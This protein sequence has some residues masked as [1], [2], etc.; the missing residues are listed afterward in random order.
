M[1]RK[2]SKEGGGSYMISRLIKALPVLI[3][4]VAL[5][6]PN[7]W[8]G[9]KKMMAIMAAKNDAMRGLTE[10]V[11]G[12]KVRSS[13]EVKNMTADSYVGKT[14][15]KTSATLS[16]IKITDVVYDSQ[17]DIA[18]ATA[19]MT[20]SEIVNIE[21]AN[22]AL[23][24]KVFKHVGFGTSSPSSAGPLKALRAAQI[25]AY[26]QLA[27]QIAGFTLESQTSVENYMLKSDLIQTKV[28][29]SL[30]LSEIVDFGWDNSGDAYV[31]MVLRVDE[32]AAM[33]GEAVVG[34]GEVIEVEGQGAI[35][36]DFKKAKAAT[37][38]P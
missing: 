33:L 19:T 37:K 29:A 13:E 9:N 15:S 20:A 6:V 27:Q 26:K 4:C 2:Y 1:A 34:A 22:V 18:K 10:Q 12:L 36:D 14:D 11:Y 30:A 16:G 17:K 38:K 25:D 3:V 28:Q 8:A 21:G 7:A 35:Q 5:F 31:K 23:N 32:V 24:G